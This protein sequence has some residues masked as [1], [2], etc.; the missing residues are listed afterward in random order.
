MVNA[1][2]HHHLQRFFLQNPSTTWRCYAFSN[3]KNRRDLRDIPS[4]C[5]TN[6]FETSVQISSLMKIFGML[7]LLHST[8]CLSQ[9]KCPI[10]PR[11]HTHTHT[12]TTFKLNI[13]KMLQGNPMLETKGTFLNAGNGS[14][15]EKQVTVNT[16]KCLSSKVGICSC[17]IPLFHIVSIF[18]SFKLLRGDTF[19]AYNI[20]QSLKKHDSW[21]LFS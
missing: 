17:R 3:S 14:E 4:T 9:K 8:A 10:C 19:G 20:P 16:W 6:L 18:S 15:N 1:D 13:W 7:T 5:A 2:F 11:K 12:H 21:L